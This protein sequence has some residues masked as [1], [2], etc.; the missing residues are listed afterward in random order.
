VDGVV[1][2]ARAG[3]THRKQLEKALHGLREVGANVVGVVLNRQKSG[4]NDYYEYYYRDQRIK[5]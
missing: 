4:N 1:L 3:S 5:N 2:V